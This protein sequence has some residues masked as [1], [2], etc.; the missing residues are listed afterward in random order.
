MKSLQESTLT[1]FRELFEKGYEKLRV[2]YTKRS[3]H[4]F[5]LCW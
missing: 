2:P 5:N 3:S 4:N 1:M